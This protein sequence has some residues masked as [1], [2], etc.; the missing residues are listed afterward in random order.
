MKVLLAHNKYQQAGG[1]DS[2][3]ESEIN[4][5]Q[6]NGITVKRYQES[7]DDI[8]FSRSNP[9]KPLAIAADTLWSRRSYRQFETT[10]KDFQPDIVHIHN[11][12]PRISPSA[13][14]ACNRAGVPVIQTLHNFR[15]FCAAG[16]LV[17]NDQHCDQCLDHHFLRA[18]KH[19]CYRGSLGASAVLATMQHLH[20]AIGTYNRCVDRFIALTPFARDWFVKAGLPESK[21]VVK[22]NF[23]DHDPGMRSGESGQYLF[24]GRLA[25]DKGINY[26]IEAWKMAGNRKLVV[27]GDGPERPQLE[28]AIAEHNLNITMMGFQAKETVLELMGQ[29]K[30]LLIPSQWYEM[31]PMTIAESLAV[32]TPVLASRLGNL[33]SIIFD[34]VTGFLFD[35]QQPASLISALEKLES[36]D[37]PALRESCRDQFLQRYS[38]EAAID[39]LLTIYRSVT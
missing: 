16:N 29:A 20:H 7:N 13:Y 24:A 10:L 38:R 21:V 8:Q 31:F 39:N 32:G 12:F 37:Y 19:R 3:F 28:A 14:Y 2:V 6:D 15:L 33:P 23:L 17:R 9:F 27:L 36:C 25:R 26:L 11:T 18:A 30:A 34:D 22:P 5:L 1:E 4:L 35:H